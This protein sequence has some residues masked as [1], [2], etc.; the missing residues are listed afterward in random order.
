VIERGDLDNRADVAC[1]STAALAEAL[2]LL[3]RP[4]LELTVQA[5]QPG[6]DLC[7]ALSLLPAGSSAVRQLSTGFLRVLGPQALEARRRRVELQPLAVA[8]GAGDRLRLAIAAAAWPAIAVN[9]GDGSLPSGPAGP[10][11]RV[12]SLS[13]ALE[14]S[15]LRLEPP[16]Q[17]SHQTS[18]SPGAN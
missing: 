6:F 14:G 4:S 15:L 2:W 8:L 5:D 17:D 7:V 18:G 10:Q 16:L 9:P 11:H 13:L 12:I 3:G 1:F